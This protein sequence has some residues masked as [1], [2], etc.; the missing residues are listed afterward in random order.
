MA[1]QIQ[2]GSKNVSISNQLTLDELKSV[3]AQ[4]DLVVG[5]DTGPTHMAWALNIPSVTL[6]GSTPG[7]RNT[8]TTNINY[9]IESNSKVDSTKINKSDFSI[10]DIEVNKVALKARE[11]LKLV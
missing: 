2:A 6:F 1:D 5:G 10:S 7:Y 3:I 8:Y 9:I 11:L 4:M